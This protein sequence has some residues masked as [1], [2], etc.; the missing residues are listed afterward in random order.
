MLLCQYGC[1]NPGIFQFKNGTRCCAKRFNGCPAIIQKR[2]ETRKSK[3]WKHSEESKKK[4]GDNARGR[5]LSEEWKQ[6]ISASEKGKP[7]GPKSEESKRKQSDAMKGKSP[8]NK[9]LTSEDHRVASYA[10]KQQGI[11]KNVGQVPWNKGIKKTRV[12]CD[13]R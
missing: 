3:N 12:Y 5:V 11:S 6:K 8:W 7:K 13:I 2:V 9:G 10:N 1:G 4:I